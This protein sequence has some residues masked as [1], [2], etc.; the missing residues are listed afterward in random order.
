MLDVESRSR[1]SAA[2]LID[3]ILALRQVRRIHRIT[4]VSADF[5][6]QR[7]ARLMGVH[8]LWEGRRRGLNKGVRLAISDALQKKASAAL[9]IPSDLP[10]ITPRDINRF[11]TLSD[12]HPISLTPSKDGGGTNAMLLRPPG[13]IQPAFG[14][15][16]FRRHVA[17]ARKNGFQPRVVKLRGIALD[18]DDPSDLRLLRKLS[19]RNH[20]G[21]FLK[22]LEERVSPRRSIAPRSKRAVKPKFNSSISSKKGLS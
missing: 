15:D 17:I 1:L 13:L 2:M 14:K 10:L 8:F 11:M 9:I 3:V 20:T 19:L 21:S 16:S 5:S 4:V 7:I 6:A 12:S 22:S 18:V